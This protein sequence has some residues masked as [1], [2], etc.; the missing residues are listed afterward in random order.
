MMDEET[1]IVLVVVIV[2]F[3]AIIITVCVLKFFRK[4]RGV[5]YSK[6]LKM[7]ASSVRGGLIRTYKHDISKDYYVDFNR[8]IG[9]GGCAV[10]VVGEHKMT[11]TQYAVKVIDKTKTDKNQLNRELRLLR[12]VDHT[13]IVRLFSVYD[14]SQTAY[15]VMELCSGGHLGSL[16]ARQPDKRLEENWAKTLCRQLLSA[17]AHIH[18][19]GI[20][21]RDIKLQNILVDHNSDRNAQLK[22]IDFG[23]GSKFIGNLPMRTKCGTPYTTAPEVIRKYYDERCDVWSVGVVLYI[24]LSGKR[25]FEAL[26][27]TGPLSEAGKATMIANILACR[28]NFNHR[29]WNQVSKQGIQFVKELLHPDYQTRIRSY[30]ALENPWLKG[31]VLNKQN[32]VLKSQHSIQA[33]SSMKLS[34]VNWT[35]IKPTGMMAV[36]FGMN[37]NSKEALNLRNVFQS[38]DT[39]GSGMLS[40]EEFSHALHLI[41]PDLKEDDIEELFHMI[42]IDKNGQISFSEF[43]AVSLNPQQIDIEDLNNAFDLIDEDGNGYISKDELRKVNIL[44]MCIIKLLHIYAVCMY[45]DMCPYMA[46]ATYLCVY[47]VQAPIY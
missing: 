46:H 20:A 25:P 45:V 14:T 1:V 30:E 44:I 11:H 38:I 33:I 3:C 15:F 5:E 16:I 26:N 36:V 42:D 21:H 23:Y 24:M 4:S 35:P 12:D 9:K 27:A 40:K 2:L 10:V 6:S 43:L 13:N 29:A 47:C 8:E 17:I 39:D 19:R 22:L 34:K 31:S 18:S 32:N 28:Y 37:N 7:Y 41:T